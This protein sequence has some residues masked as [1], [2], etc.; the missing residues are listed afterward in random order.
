MSFH[1]NVVKLCEYKLVRLFV[2]NSS[3]SR[4]IVHHHCHHCMVPDRSI[5]RKH[6]DL[7]ISNSLLSQTKTIFP[8]IHF[9]SIYYHL[10]YSRSKAWLTVGLEQNVHGVEVSY[11]VQCCF[12]LGKIKSASGQV[13][14]TCCTARAYH[15]FFRIKWLEVFLPPWLKC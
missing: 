6:L 12:S 10:S 14:H 4:C 7:S 5:Q 13:V 1:G 3:G 15:G 11:F 8:W 9:F 2:V